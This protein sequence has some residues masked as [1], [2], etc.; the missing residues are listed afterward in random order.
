MGWGLKST[1]ENL[2]FCQNSPVVIHVLHQYSIVTQ[3]M[4]TNK[5][6]TLDIDKF[7]NYQGMG[8]H[9]YNWGED[10]VS[11]LFTTRELLVATMIKSTV[12]R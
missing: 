5:V 4:V 12:A 7:C 10:L 3:K 11:R 8:S 9:F 2:R 6:L 1:F